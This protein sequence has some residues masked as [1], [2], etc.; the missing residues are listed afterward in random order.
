MIQ[1]K[2][3][4]DLKSQLP[5]LPVPELSATLTRLVDWITPLLTAGELA[6][7]QK[8][9]TQ[10]NETDGPILQQQLLELANR[11]DGSW[12]API[13]ET[14]YLTDRQPLQA[15]ANFAFT[16]S[17]D[18]IPEKT[19]PAHLAAEIITRLTKVYR[20]FATG[21]APVEHF[22]NDQPMDMS[23]YLNFFK[24]MRLAEVNQDHFHQGVP[25]IANQTVAIMAHQALY[26]LPVTDQNGELI[27]TSTLAAELA[28]ILADQPTNDVF[29][30]ALTGLERDTA[31]QQL[32]DLLATSP[33]QQL[34]AK[35]ADA[36]FSL[37]LVA[38]P[39]DQAGH[40][41]ETLLDTYNRFVDK[42]LQVIVY[43]DN[44]VGFAIEHSRVDGVPAL[45]LISEA[46]AGLTDPPV[47]IEKVSVPATEFSITPT[48]ANQLKA[49]QAATQAIA[50]RIDV[51]TAV[52][53]QFGKAQLKGHHVS[54]DAFFHI[55]L[56]LAMYRLTHS[57][58]SIYEPVSMRQFYQGRTENARSLS[59]EKKRFVLAFAANQPADQV[60]QLFEE[61]AKAHVQRISD[62]QKGLG[63]ER[64]LLGLETVYHKDPEKLLVAKALF[65]SPQ[66]AKL[67]TDYLSTTSIPFPVIQG[68]TFAP[69]S[70]HGYGVYYGILPNE[71]RL[72]VSSW[73]GE[74]LT[75]TDWL[76]AIQQSLVDLMAFL[77]K[78]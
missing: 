18:E 25:E 74:A 15:S 39:T 19:A 65:T 60:R 33:N 37:S 7:F 5:A 45:N 36:L 57:W 52:F 78:T 42:T 53:N 47:T 17:P 66:L 44:Q 10:F 1:T 43:S 55:A 56:A 69:T 16:V 67:R 2:Y 14:S 54:P 77:D 27:A 4:T 6:D 23:Y 73:Q 26:F 70:A 71:I 20:D 64:H 50:D 61:A 35:V 24:S 59:T 75:P 28:G 62:A 46:M 41:K 3:T 68:L 29:P 51:G 8:L 58:H 31:A 49:D 30:G 63:V 38:A 22:R 40:L 32:T 11:T 13:W 48:L 21:Q 72:S 34:W 9:V 12:L 76:Q